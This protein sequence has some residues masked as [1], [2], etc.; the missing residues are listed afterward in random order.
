MR[1]AK[2]SCSTPGC[3][4]LAEDGPRCTT[5]QKEHRQRHDTQR[6][7][8]SARGYTEDHRRLRILC[9][10]RDEWKC[11]D[12]GFEPDV[13]R[14][15][16]AYGLDE[17]STEVIL[18]ELRDRWQRGDVHLHGDHDIPIQDRPDLRLD[19]GNYR[20]R[21][22]KCHSAKTMREVNATSQRLWSRPD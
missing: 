4:R 8:P 13:V 10:Q 15:A 7:S 19:L 2:R 11:V 21:C 1:L 6:G 20:T 3:G 17:P 5:C 12:C 14:D 22:S 9:F 16:R 18:A